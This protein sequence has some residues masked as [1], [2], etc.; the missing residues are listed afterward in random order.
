MH[1]HLPVKIDASA[2]TASARFG[3]AAAMKDQP[4]EAVVRTW[5]R[6]VR[7][8][9]LALASIERKLKAAELP[10]LAWYD[11]LLELERAE[12]NG[13]RPFELEQQML[14][15]QYN[16][17]RLL[18][19]LARAGYVERRPCKNDKRGQVLVLSRAGRAMRRRMWA[20]Y[21]PAMQAAIGDRLSPS[22]ID[23]L[24]SLLESLLA[25]VTSPEA[26]RA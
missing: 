1:L 11:V 4:N 22:E 18:E 16:L 9:Q 14:L 12:P 3:D 15:A 5:T 8:Q 26:H 13:L 25:G 10:P 6:L 2:L 23:D 24:G 17:S 21:G 7:A 19:R 20:I